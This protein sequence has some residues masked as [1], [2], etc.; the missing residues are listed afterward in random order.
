MTP[1]GQY[2]DFDDCV[3][4]NSDKADPKAYCAVVK[5]RTEG[6]SL[7]VAEKGLI[8][9]EKALLP[10]PADTVSGLSYGGASTF[11]ECEAYQDATQKQMSLE[12]LFYVALD[13]SR[14]VLQNP[15]ITPEDKPS[16]LGSV[17]QG[18]AARVGQLLGSKS[19]SSPPS[20]SPASPSAP[21]SLRTSGLAFTKDTT[22]AIRWV[23]FVSGNF[24]DR[25]REIFP[26]DSHAEFVDYLDRSKDY[27][28]LRVWHTPGADI[29]RAD[30]AEFESGF[31]LMS[32]VVDKDKEYVAENLASMGDMGMSHGFRFKYRGPGVIDKYRS[33]EVSVLPAP[34]AAFPW[35][36]INF[37][38]EEDMKPEKRAFL[39]K[40]LGA[41][42]A[43]QIIQQAESLQKDLVKAGVEWKDI[44]LGPESAS[45]PASAPV[46]ASAPLVVGF[47]DEAEYASI[48]S[49]PEM[50]ASLQ[51]QFTDV[52]SIF[53]ASIKSLQQENQ[54]LA[55]AVSVKADDMLASLLT[56]R[57]GQRQVVPASRSKDSV[58]APT[59]PLAQKKPSL[60]VDAGVVSSLVGRI[61]SQSQ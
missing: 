13:L 59:D 38:K 48:K 51:Q 22:G 1:F 61:Q 25:E 14:N 35:S 56:P 26:A 37:V 42:R 54:K 53:D 34:F 43:A 2:E 44:D 55:L 39:E 46:P 4:K 30:W 10:I 41:D 11:E 57:G 6:K 5:R 31:L 23:G 27:P 3:S 36:S 32:G 8:Q 28:V 52:T 17:A 16:R 18:L 40:A 50:L 15:A 9:H 45:A 21:A 49:L 12:N 58:V 7:T 60:P 20:P 29:G 47:K 19:Q 33:F 24:K